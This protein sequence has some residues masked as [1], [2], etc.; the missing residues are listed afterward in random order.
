MLLF[1]ARGFLPS[2]HLH[3]RYVALSKF[4]AK[5][6]PFAGA[7]PDLFLALFGGGVNARGQDL[8]QDQKG[9]IVFDDS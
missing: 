9:L 2:S 1:P 7:A 5:T 3:S 8:L 6:K 4:Q